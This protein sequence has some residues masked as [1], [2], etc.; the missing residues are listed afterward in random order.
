MLLISENNDTLIN[1]IHTTID[2]PPSLVWSWESVLGIHHFHID[3]N[4]PC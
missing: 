3:H 1:Q 4:A 2:S